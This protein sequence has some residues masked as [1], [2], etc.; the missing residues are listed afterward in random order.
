M[1]FWITDKLQ[2]YQSIWYYKDFAAAI[3]GTVGGKISTIY[4][5]IEEAQRLQRAILHTT[6]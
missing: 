2:A 6:L 5:N 1:A 3:R 4:G